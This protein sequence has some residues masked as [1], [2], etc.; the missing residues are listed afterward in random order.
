MSEPIQSISQGNYI[1]ATQQEISHDNTLSGNGTVDSPLGVVPGYNETVLWEYTGTARG[2]TGTYNLSESWKN[3]EKIRITE[4][5]VYGGPRPGTED[6]VFDTK[7]ANDYK[8]MT[9]FNT[10]MVTDNFNSTGK[11]KYFSWYAYNF[12]ADNS[13]TLTP[14]MVWFVN[15]NSSPK[16]LTGRMSQEKSRG[17]YKIVGINR[18]SGSNT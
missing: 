16:A 1:L 6:H 13:I 5:C 9:I 8:N 12:S 18:I 17:T 7:L 4:G 2:A 15:Y 11:E 10:D 3:F 14:S